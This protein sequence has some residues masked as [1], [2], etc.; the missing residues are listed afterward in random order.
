MTSERTSERTLNRRQRLMLLL[1]AAFL[2]SAYAWLSSGRIPWETGTVRVLVLELLPPD[3]EPSPG[4]LRL[5]DQTPSATASLDTAAG[6]IADE[7]AEYAPSDPDLEVEFVIAGPHSVLVDPPNL[8][9]PGITGWE[10]LTRAVGYYRYFDRLASQLGVDFDDY[11]ARLVLLLES[12]AG[13]DLESRSRADPR[14]RFGVVHLEPELRDPG[15]ALITLLHE[16]GHTFG[17]TDKYDPSTFLAVWP[18]GFAEPERTPPL[19][20][21]RAELMAVDIPLT[22][23]DEREPRVL[24]DVVVGARTAAEFGW[25]PARLADQQYVGLATRP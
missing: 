7:Y 6:W 17:A 14:H 18:E 25:I 11:D 16:L 4:L 23:T 2:V 1:F 5:N 12:G 8:D 9:S 22:S 15:Y 21:R 24:R 19:P 3:T 13:S 20:Q 10:R